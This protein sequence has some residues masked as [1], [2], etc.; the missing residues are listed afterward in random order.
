VSEPKRAFPSSAQAIEDIGY[1]VLPGCVAHQI[2]HD[3]II[4]LAG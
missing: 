4:A 2:F 3:T 1:A